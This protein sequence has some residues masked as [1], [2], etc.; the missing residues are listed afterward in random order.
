[1]YVW[2]LIYLIQIAKR[3]AYHGCVVGEAESDPVV[4]G[5]QG[6][7]DL[8]VLGTLPLSHR[9]TTLDAAIRWIR[10]A[11]VGDATPG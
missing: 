5:L 8:A 6:N 4:G 11:A 1:M 9:L 3:I 10:K 7:P 2:N